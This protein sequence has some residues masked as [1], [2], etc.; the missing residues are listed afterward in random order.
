MIE[1]RHMENGGGTAETQAVIDSLD[2]L[3]ECVRFVH[4]KGRMLL[5]ENQTLPLI[6]CK[7]G[8]ATL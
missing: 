5:E 8:G 7:P 6:K 3:P 1:E 4:I 2:L